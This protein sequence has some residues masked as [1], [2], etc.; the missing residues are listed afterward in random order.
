MFIFVE[1]WGSLGASIFGN[2]SLVANNTRSRLPSRIS[3]R[4]LWLCFWQNSVHCGLLGIFYTPY[5]ICLSYYA[6]DRAVFYGNVTVLILVNG[7][8][9]FW[10]R[11]SFFRKF[12][13]SYSIENVEN[14]QWSLY[15]NMLISQ[16][17][18]YFESP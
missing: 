14:S 5:S 2:S 11:F 17:E 4:F 6:S 16:M 7:A 9:V 1:F 12:V 10:K 18:G 15:K 3:F 13:S 8:P